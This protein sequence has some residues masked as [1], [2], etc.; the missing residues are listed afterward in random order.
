VTTPTP[1]DETI[2]K[3]RAKEKLALAIAQEMGYECSRTADLDG[4]SHEKV[5][6]RFWNLH[7]KQ[8]KK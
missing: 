3:I 4:A 1:M 6:K 5:W 8:F 2:A 7:G